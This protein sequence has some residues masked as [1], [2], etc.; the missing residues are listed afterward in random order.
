[1]AEILRNKISLKANGIWHPGTPARLSCGPC[2]VCW[3]D[4]INP[5]IIS[6]LLSAP[7]T[8]HRAS[9]TEPQALS[10]PP[11]GQMERPLASWNARRR[12]VKNHYYTRATHGIVEVMWSN[13]GAFVERLSLTK[14][15]LPNASAKL[16]LFSDM[17]MG[18]SGLRAISLWLPRLPRLPRLPNVC[19]YFRE[20]WYI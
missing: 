10:G 12:L 11:A 15:S 18:W 9:G 2:I 1:M 4:G 20:L 14:P 16:L 8:A 17:A 7:G 5:Y 19:V 6:V 3:Q 13:R